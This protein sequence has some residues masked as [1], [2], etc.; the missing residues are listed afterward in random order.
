[1]V[2]DGFA[3]VLVT[4]VTK[5]FSDDRVLELLELCKIIFVDWRVTPVVPL[6]RVE[7]T[8]VLAA[9]VLVSCIISVSNG[10]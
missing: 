1:M 7:T 9:N 10:D 4:L 5:L 6:V 3:I 2:T 8:R